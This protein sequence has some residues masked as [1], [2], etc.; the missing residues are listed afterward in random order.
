[1]AIHWVFA[2][3]PMNGIDEETNKKF[4]ADLSVSGMATSEDGKQIM[5]LLIGGASVSRAQAP[6]FVRDHLARFVFM[7]SVLD[8]K[9]LKGAAVAAEAKKEE[10]AI[11][12]DLKRTY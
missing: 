12:A 7:N 4:W 2:D 5:A 3:P 9:P 1:M 11:L 6:G 10:E 8:G